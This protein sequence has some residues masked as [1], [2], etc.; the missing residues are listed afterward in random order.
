MKI[1]LTFILYFVNQSIFAQLERGIWHSGGIADFY[2]YKQ[3]YE[4]EFSP[5]DANGT[6]INLNANIGYFI[7][8]KFSLGLKPGF[9]IVKAETSG[10]AIENTQRYS[11]G[12]FARYYL[13]NMDNRYNIVTEGSYHWGFL[14]G[15]KTTGSIKG[16]SILVGPVIYFNSSMGLEFLMGYRYR[17]EKFNDINRNPFLIDKQNGLFIGVGLQIHLQKED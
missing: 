14:G 17:Y 13:L 3:N 2:S 12:P 9:S 8:N 7:S 10:G 16:A 6:N 15:D 4:T 11:I 1:V 5:Y